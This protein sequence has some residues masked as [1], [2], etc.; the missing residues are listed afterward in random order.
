MEMYFFAK[1]WL[2]SVWEMLQKWSKVTYLKWLRYASEDN[3]GAICVLG[4]FVI[5]E[6]QYST[7][8]RPS[9]LWPRSPIFQ[10]TFMTSGNSGSQGFNFGK[11]QNGDEVSNVKL[12]PWAEGDPRLFVKIHR[13]GWR[14]TNF[15]GFYQ[16]LHS[17]TC[18]R[19]AEVSS[20]S[21]TS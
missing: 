12:P 21:G 4:G 14:F 3:I 8:F 16:V 1:M 20:G 9:V 10:A 19:D 11:R 5:R 15:S 13:Q 7:F 2:K 18:S 17:R 6:F